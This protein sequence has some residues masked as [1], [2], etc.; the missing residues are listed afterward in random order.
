MDLAADEAGNRRGSVV[1]Q[2]CAALLLL[3]LMGYVI[4]SVIMRAA[5]APLS[6]VAEISGR[7]LMAPLVFA[8]IAVA[9]AR[10]EHLSVDALRVPAGSRAAVLVSVL[11]FV[12]LVALMA[13]ITWYGWEAAVEARA[14][15]E[16]GIDSGHAVWL[17][18]FGV[19]LMGITCIVLAVLP[20]LSRRDGPMQL[21]DDDVSTPTQEGT[22]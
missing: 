7:W 21:T 15:G 20:V 10:G 8:G 3:S 13:L 16:R 12:M 14:Q 22:R 9:L 2:A 6:G 4:V 11:R 18:R 19:P 17:S 1:L 5:G